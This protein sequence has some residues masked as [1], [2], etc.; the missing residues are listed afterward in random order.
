M[1]T[2]FAKIKHA[3]KGTNINVNL[4]PHSNSA[5]PSSI[6]PTPLPPSDLPSL[7]NQSIGAE[8]KL[9]RTFT[10]RNNTTHA[11]IETDT[12]TASRT[13]L[14]TLLDALDLKVCNSRGAITCSQGSCSSSIDISSVSSSL[15]PSVSAR[16][17]TNSGSLLLALN[18]FTSPDSLDTLLQSFY[19]ILF[20]NCSHH[21]RPRPPFLQL[22]PPSPVGPPNYN[23][24]NHFH[25]LQAKKNYVRTLFKAKRGHFRKLC[26][27]F[28]HDPMTDTSAEAPPALSPF[29]QTPSK[30][31]SPTAPSTTTPPLSLSPYPSN[32]PSTPYPPFTAL[33]LSLALCNLRLKKSCGLDF[34]PGPFSKWLVNSFPNLFLGLFNICFSVGHFPSLWKASRLLLLPKRSTST[35][36]NNNC[37]PIILLPILGKLL[38]SLMAF[39][40]SHHYEGN[41]L[42]HPLQF[43]FCR[44]R[45]TADALSFLHHNIKQSVSKFQCCLL[46]SLD[47]KLDFDHLWHPALFGRLVAASCP[48]P[49]SNSTAPSSPT[50]PSTSSTEGFLTPPLPRGDDIQILVSGPPNRLPSLAQS[51]LDLIHS[52]C[53]DEKLSL[54]PISPWFYPFSAT[55]PIF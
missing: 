14:N 8:C 5:S 12:D 52:W 24:S 20:L 19:S 50:A 17:L 28:T 41:N 30:N 53:L 51:S 1:D 22:P 39:R 25:A 10:G 27:S 11:I 55:L 3:T 4:P 42:L 44:R 7:L 13:Y 9:V 46:I 49:S 2:L 37:H 47:I 34:L 6:S 29:P 18:H 15:L 54:T 40:L 43:G 32:P 16:L 38:E 31:P 23:L 48:P 33:K 26:S 21:L 35:D 36:F 45:S